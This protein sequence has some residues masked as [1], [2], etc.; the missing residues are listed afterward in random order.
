[1]ST[2]ILIQTVSLI[3]IFNHI[4]FKTDFFAFYAKAIKRFIPFN[5]YFYLMIEEYF[6]R[7]P[8]DY[9][10]NSYIEYFSSKKSFSKNFLEIFIL[11]LISCPICLT[12]WLSILSSIFLGNIFYLGIIF[13]LVRCLDTL[14]N[15]F[16]KVH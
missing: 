16:L 12:T 3:A 5:M 1:M 4:W 10:Y 9:M 11:K 8:E 15:F 13:I 2:L 14:L 6:I 7:P